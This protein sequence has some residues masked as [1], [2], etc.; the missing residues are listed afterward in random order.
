MFVHF[1]KFIYFDSTKIKSL[2]GPRP[3]NGNLSDKPIF[4][5]GLK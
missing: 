1:A 4:K 3:D 2:F 5:H